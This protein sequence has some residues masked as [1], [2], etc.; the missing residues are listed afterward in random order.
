MLV[1]FGV[2]MDQTGVNSRQAADVAA[3][4]GG[5]KLLFGAPGDCVHAS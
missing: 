5:T 2:H 3:I 4:F 1:P